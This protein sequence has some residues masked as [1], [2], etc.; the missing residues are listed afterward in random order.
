MDIKLLKK[1]I[2]VLFLNGILGNAYATSK[3]TNNNSFE[4]NYN[5]TDSI[6]TPNDLRI[7]EILKFNQKNTNTFFLSPD[8]TL[9]GTGS[10]S[11]VDA[12]KICTT[13]NTAVF[14]FTNL[15]TT[16]ATNKNYTIKWGDGTP[17]WTSSTNWASTTHT[18][19][20][21][22]R[23]LTYII[24]GTDGTIT[25]KTYT[26]FLGSNPAIA[27]GNPGNTDICI[28][29]SLTFPIT[30]TQNNDPGTIYTVTIND[31]T[32]PQVFTHATLP[33]SITH[34]FNKKSC[35]TTSS[36][37]STFYPN[38]FSINIVATN[39]CTSSS[40]GVVPIYVSA[41]PVAQ[42]SGPTK[43]CINT[44]V[45]FANTSEGFQVSG[46]LCL[47]PKNV[48]SISPA[49]GYTVSGASVL[50]NDYGS[51]DASV[52]ALGTNDLC[53]TFTVAG[54]YSITI[55]SGSKCGLS[56]Y[57]D[58][59]TR[60]ICIEPKLVAAFT[61]SAALGCTPLAVS[62]TN[63]TVGVD[64]C[65]PTGY[66]W[67][68]SYSPANC[69]GGS[70]NYTY[71]GG[72]NSTSSEPKFNFI[73][74]GT[75]TLTLNTSNSCG[76][77][78]VSKTIVV[79]G[80]PK[81]SIQNISNICQTSAITTVSPSANISKCTSNASAMTYAWS[82]PGGTPSTASTENPGNITYNT[83]GTFTVSLTVTNEC[84]TKTA[85]NKSFTIHPLP[86]IS[87]A[88]SVC[89]NKTSKLTASIPGNATSWSS[90]PSGIV[91]ISSAGLVTGL[92]AG[93][94]TITY[95]DINGC[96]TSEIFK[97]NPLPT[98]TI[99]ADK[100][101]C[102]G[103]NAEI[104]L[105]G[106]NGVAPYTFTYNINFGANLTATTVSGN[107]V[108][109]SV[110]TNATGTFTYNL[111]SVSDASSTNC[112]NNQTGSATITIN[113]IPTI[114]LQPVNPQRICIGESINAFEAVVV[115]GAGN[116][117][118][119]WYKN[120]N[121]S[122]IGGTAIPGATND[123]YS[124]P[125]FLTA[126][127][128]Y[129]YVTA[130]LT[131]SG[132]GVATSTSAEVT[133][134]P[135]PKITKQPITP[136]TVCQN[137]AAQV[138]TI[139]ADSGNG[140]PLEY[141]WYSNNFNS[142]LAGTAIPNEVY[143]TFSPPT[144]TL[145]TFYY[146]CI[147]KPVGLNC[148]KISNV[149]VVNVVSGPS[150]TIQPQP[151]EICVGGTPT[152]LTVAYA[153][154]TGSVYYQWF[155]NN[156]NSNAGGS[157]ITGA[158][159]A[160]YNPPA[161]VKGTVYYY[162]EITFSAGGCNNLVSD[163]A[164]VKINEG[165]NIAAK[166]VTICSGE[167]F[168]IVPDNT[169]GDTVPV[170]TT[171]TWVY[172]NFTPSSAINRAS[173]E[174]SAQ[175][176]ITQTL[177]NTS[178]N[179]VTLI[180]TVK[181]NGGICIG[182]DF[183]V[184]VTVNPTI[185]VATVITNSTCNGLKNGAIVATIT[186]GTP[187][188]V[189][190]PYNILWS[191]PNGF[192]AT[193]ANISNLGA[194]IYNLSVDA[195]CTFTKSYTITEPDTLVLIT[196]NEKDITCF[197]DADGAIA[198]S[199]SGGTAPY[200]YQ[201]TK[202]NIPFTNT[203]DIS[204]LAPGTYKITVTDANNCTPVSNTYNITQPELLEVTLVNQTP[205]LCFGTA[206]GVININT[207]G[208]TQ[209]VKSS[210]ALDYNYA[211][212]GPDGFV[213][214]DQNLTNLKAGTYNL[215]VTDN[216]G[217]TDDLEV[218]I[219]ETDEIIITA[220]TTPITCYGLNNASITVNISGGT[221]A[222]KISWS[223]LSTGLFQENLSAGDYT[224]KVVDAFGCEKELTINIPEVPVFNV[225]PISKNISCNGAND[226]SIALN[227]TGDT[228]I[229]KLVWSDGSTAG[230]TRN[231]LAPGTYTVTLNNGSPCE[232]VRT[233]TII[234]PLE[235]A[236]N[237]GFT[238]P[239][240]CSASNNGM[241]DLQVSGGTSPYNF[242]WTK[243]N[244]PF[245]SNEDIS[246]LGAG[247]Y[248]VSVT[249]ANFCDVKFKTF[250]LTKPTVLR[251]DL[252]SQSSKICFGSND[253]S[254]VINA[255]GGTPIE[256][257]PGVFD[258]NYSWTGPNGFLSSAQ[259]LNYLYAGTYNLVISDKS[260]CTQNLK[261]IIPES[262]EIIIKATTT[263]I[264]CFGMNNGT[265]NVSVTGGIPNYQITWSNGAS[266]LNQEN[267][268]A[269]S[270]TITIKDALGCVKEMTFK[271]DAVPALTLNPIVNNNSCFGVNDGSIDLNFTANSTNVT[272]LWS[273]GSTAGAVRNNLKPGVYKVTVNSGSPCQ[274]E[275]TFEI[276][277]PSDLTLNAI[278]SQPDT[279]SATDN[280][281]I[282][283]QVSGGSAPYSFQWTKNNVTF[284]SSE[285]VSNIGAGT[286]V[287]KVTDANNCVVK[288]ET[289]NIKKPT[290]LN[291][292]LISQT[293]QLCYGSAQG[294]IVISATG[295]TP[296]LLSSGALDYNYA[297]TGPNGFVSTNKN[298]NNLV[299]GTYKLVVSD[300]SG[301]NQNLSVT[302]LPSDEIM[303]SAKTTPITCN[304]L[305]NA[306]IEVTISGGN[307]SY[308]I[309][310]SNKGTGLIQKNL[311]PGD[312]TITVTDELGCE[313]K[314][315][316]TIDD[317][318][319][320]DVNPIVK[321]VSCFGAN[322]GSITLNF[323]GGNSGIKLTWNDGVS[324]GTTRN[325]LSAGI[326][327]VSINNG[328]PCELERTFEIIQPKALEINATI[329]N[330]NNCNNSY[331]G[332]INLSVSGGSTP[333]TFEWSNGM[334]TPSLDRLVAGNYMVTVTD[335]NGC[336][337]KEKF[338]LDN[339]A[340]LKLNVNSKTVV[341]CEKPTSQQTFDA[342]VYGGKPPYVFTWS[343]GGSGKSSSP[344][345]TTS[346]NG[347]ITLLVKD[348]NGC[349]ANYAYDVKLP[350]VNK[351]DF[352]NNSIGY[353]SY[354]MFSIND[355]IQFT[356][357]TV[358]DYTSMLWDFGDGTFSTESN[359][360]HT[361]T[362]PKH[363]VITQKVTYPYGCEFINKVTLEVEKGYLL[364]VPNAFTPN[365]DSVNDTF[366]PVTKALTN[367]RM[368]V[369]DTWGS[370][371]YSETGDSLVGWNGLIKGTYSENGNFFCQVSAQTFYGEL[372]TA[373]TTFALIK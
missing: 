246:N 264:T 347:L 260:G 365:N 201:W 373:S 316:I 193:T 313:K 120:T 224:I 232:I 64:Q 210:G 251:V 263:P 93:T 219:L 349:S 109:L 255:S 371:I 148:E 172:P 14:T 252:I 174:S 111:V 242:S 105:K 87:G 141:Q 138:L 94:T 225:N 150:I 53:V 89:V 181:P 73:E 192:T 321:N 5:S 188:S 345:M 359:P 112:V 331:S 127:T 157:P 229:V 24:E 196:D 90:S 283:L 42:F 135:Q 171:Y 363:Y 226:G 330:P 140:E 328:S 216:S 167:T 36:D 169:N 350:E 63:S 285:D 300:A 49:T 284:S 370:L 158:N 107:S 209:I 315:T 329:Q 11:T 43:A 289:Y 361:Y 48:W 355:P 21:G 259:N 83:T 221:P 243:N 77:S 44:Q 38:S 7:P 213:S 97:V 110:P 211:W 222:Y 131:A 202:N 147:V 250:V 23:T 306:S 204:N 302:I 320:I 88:L 66:Q 99:T 116:T 292:N 265:I 286:Y 228:S 168:I 223:N 334:T 257:A 247:I 230:T 85:T 71:T 362:A 207:Q 154:G 68:V 237:A 47:E 335:A 364:V 281:M 62:T 244:I 30:G 287:V 236:I 119:Q 208:G 311:A 212:S 348:A 57:T 215:I 18:Y 282:D 314:L 291:L 299:A 95:K 325:N 16:T 351:P 258:Y 4:Y 129:Y 113:E 35:G 82:F 115:G 368:D 245:S 160:N 189:A 163:T 267:L 323:V 343:N 134:V 240:A 156:I 200:T 205:K 10:G 358:G 279:C 318:P 165:L 74:P 288:T 275:R 308:T 295:G 104:T 15:S 108:V 249:D 78:P 91:S 305:N 133:V 199:I 272:L 45:C 70:G 186:G 56:D 197:Q 125:A 235:L 98:A 317:T 353:T 101:I 51:S 336:S 268:S 22:L 121:N 357:T 214:T 144:T 26:V 301:C 152:K 32:P 123:K 346:K 322:D 194:G 231:N 234:E 59:Y 164:E 8:A 274:I 54:T 206:T 106:A 118:F 179:P 271:I 296:I 298:L 137:S 198:I 342:E 254:I 128:F 333:Y 262:D 27:L 269:G 122:S 79:K 352:E 294:S 130:T 337:I 96:T 178:R 340:P 28:G 102:K 76:S 312:Y 20:V 124:P 166:N 184:T 324:S 61:T 341:D 29:D 2:F 175:N 34:Q 145:G 367:V 354:G 40:V 55:R 177:I 217:C 239:D 41:L 86:T 270:Y 162:C 92:A 75:Y 159:S 176:N 84:G 114:S 290:A 366:R 180:Y 46:G 37:G 13:A 227:L 161:L 297:W 253:G 309:D 25:T 280:G 132:C 273:D 6:G 136:Q 360:V 33:T 319:A 67:N 9:G 304:G 356:N 338:T 218:T 126:G 293:S 31:G 233:F 339:I 100:T 173:S 19:A 190:K 191:G 50:G 12:F 65:P 203:E 183:T 195:G 307:P 17:D 182:N 187:V 369:Y 81:V 310:W 248:N 276:I 277:S 332:A 256:I 266:G 170:G 220:T 146:Y 143:D 1:I 80:P 151:S 103:A 155:S 39:L 326:Y 139:V 261:V 142:T 60:T 327:S 58:T 52:W 185:D 372:I 344:S 72:T 69:G 3:L 153:N 278:V 149:A 238:Q 117:N 241:I 303:I